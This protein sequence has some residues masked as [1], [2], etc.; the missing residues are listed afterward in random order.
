MYE[1]LFNILI[2]KQ[3]K[4]GNKNSEILAL[5]AISIERSG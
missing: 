2:T 5:L 3:K 4:I 1:C